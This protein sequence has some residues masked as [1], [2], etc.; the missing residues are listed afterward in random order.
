MA[1]NDG[2]AVELVPYAY[3]PIVFGPGKPGPSP[4]SPYAAAL[5]QAL[6]DCAGTVLNQVCYAGGSVTLDGGG[7]LTTPGQVATLDGV[8][9]LTLVSPDAGHWSVALVRLAADSPT[10]GLG[11]T[12]L[13][14]GNVAIRNLTLFRA[15]AA[16]GDV[17]P[18]LSFSSSPV[19]GQDA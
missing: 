13:A 11:L 1:V 19:P 5:S 6:A 17:A 4:A 8:S 7:P 2:A 18:A 15:A 16:N 14:F 3:L 9:G 12:L 10:P